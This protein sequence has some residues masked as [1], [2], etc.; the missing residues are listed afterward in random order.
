MDQLTHYRQVIKQL[1]GE[2]ARR[3]PA[4]PHLAY[5]T[6]FDRH[7]DSYALVAIGWQHARRIH[8]FVVHLEIVNDK[9]WI[10]ADNTDLDIAAELERAGIP[11]HQIVLG[12]HPPQVRP[13]TEYAA[14]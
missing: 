9:I 8:H 1:L 13:L 10:Q 2:L 7:A 3:R 4:N 12:F 14:A 11:K 5:Q 6:L